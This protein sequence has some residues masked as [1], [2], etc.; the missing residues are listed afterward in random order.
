VPVDHIPFFHERESLFVSQQ[1]CSLVR[2]FALSVKIASLRF[3]P[4][5]RPQLAAQKQKTKPT[6]P[7]VPP[8]APA[9]G[10]AEPPVKTTL[11][12]W[13]GDD[14]DVNGF[15]AGEKR[16][17][18]GRKKRKK[19]REAQAVPQNWDDIYD[20]SR[21]NNYEEYKH[22][23]EK[24][25]EVREWKDRLYAHRM[26][27]R[28]SSDMESDEEYSRPMNRMSHQ[29]LDIMGCSPVLQDNFPLR[30]T[31]LRLLLPVLM[32][33]HQNRPQRNHPQPRHLQSLQSQFQTMQLERKHL[34]DVF[35]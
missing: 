33:C 15:Y 6:L 1:D 21:P 31:T 27:R 7:K 14:D 17:R 34:L 29:A 2:R 4:T 11:A 8:A 16:Q 23:D 30:A 20:P 3:Q 22:S 19:N 32:M 24:I 26:A 28:R 5:K 25:R 18:G 35:G 12:D 13:A 9:A 10:V